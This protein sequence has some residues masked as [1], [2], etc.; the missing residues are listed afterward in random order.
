MTNLDDP[1]TFLEYAGEVSAYVVG[2]APHAEDTA[3]TCAT[4]AS[5]VDIAWIGVCFLR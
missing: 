2:L 1:W 4:I 3:T 5:Q